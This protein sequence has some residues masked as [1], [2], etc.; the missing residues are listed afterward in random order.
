MDDLTVKTPDQRRQLLAQA[1]ATSLAKPGPRRVETQSDFS[2][3]VVVGKPPN[4]VL[5]LLLS[6]F[7]VGVWLIVWLIVAASGGEKRFMIAVD[8]WGN[9]TISAL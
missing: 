1:L 9:T 8:E 4:H 2:A 3:I 6:V 7:T 5:H